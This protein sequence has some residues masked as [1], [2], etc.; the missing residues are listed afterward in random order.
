[1]LY[2]QNSL[3]VKT[4]FC[5][6]FEK[7]KKKYGKIKLLIKKSQMKKKTSNNIYMFIYKLQKLFFN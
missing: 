3:K 6:L 7:K 4:K 1:M 5:F 2:S